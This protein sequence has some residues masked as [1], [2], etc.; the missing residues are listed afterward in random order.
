MRIERVR[1]T[2]R[3]IHALVD[4]LEDSGHTS[5]LERDLLL[6]YI[7]DLYEEIGVPGQ[8]VEVEETDDNVFDMPV[9]VAD[10][11]EAHEDEDL[12]DDDPDESEITHDPEEQVTYYSAPEDKSVSDNEQGFGSAL[13]EEDVP[14]DTSLNRFENPV[15]YFPK[16][17]SDETPVE[18]TNSATPDPAMYDLDLDVEQPSERLLG[19]FKVAH[20]GDIAEHPGL[21]RIDSLDRAMGINERIMAIN[22]LFGGDNRFFNEVLKKLNELGSFEEARELLLKG[23]AMQFSWDSEDKMEHAGRFVKLVRRRYL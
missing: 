1:Q 15:R 21:H 16:G 2:L 9:Q 14:I 23:P 11:G 18:P 12:G 19:L 6:R 3:K 13:P 4:N 10:Q 7:R 8:A 5:A 20:S 22:E 17:N